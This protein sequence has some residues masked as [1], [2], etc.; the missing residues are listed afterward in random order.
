MLNDLCKLGYNLFGLKEIYQF[1]AGR[2]QCIIRCTPPLH[3]QP[4]YLDADDN[5]YL[6]SPDFDIQHWIL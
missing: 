3:I 1:L 5:F 6:R 2:K 4:G